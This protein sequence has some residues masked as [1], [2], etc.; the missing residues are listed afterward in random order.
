M[1]RFLYTASD[2]QGALHKGEIEALDH[3][4][5]VHKLTEMGLFL[6]SFTDPDTA[7]RG[8]DKSDV[9]EVLH[10]MEKR[11]SNTLVSQRFSYTEFFRRLNEKTFGR[12]PRW[13]QNAV[14]ILLLLAF[15]SRFLSH[16]YHFT[17]PVE[18]WKGQIPPSG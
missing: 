16:V 9:A 14:L 6:V 5:L 2:I 13:A 11:G 15:L 7:T 10:E 17:H 8:Y 18:P 1:T 12:L 4:D 3:A